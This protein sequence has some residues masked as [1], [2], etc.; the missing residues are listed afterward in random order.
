MIFYR[1]LFWP[2]WKLE[3]NENL[4]EIRDDVETQL[5]KYGKKLIREQIK[6]WK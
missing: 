3:E 6:E 5:Y 2:W 4:D 1:I